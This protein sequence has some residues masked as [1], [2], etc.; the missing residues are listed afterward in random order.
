MHF[1]FYYLGF[2]S[3]SRVPTFYN[4]VS[5]A[6]YFQRTICNY[7]LELFLGHLTIVCDLRELPMLGRAVTFPTSVPCTA[8]IRH[9]TLW[10]WR[11][12]LLSLQHFQILKELRCTTPAETP[13][14]TGAGCPPYAPTSTSVS[15]RVFTFLFQTSL[16]HHFWKLKCIVANDFSSPPTYYSH[17]H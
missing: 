6:Q 11:S 14:K 4:Q 5:L 17:N 12:P 7:S 15:Q 3:H 16:L 9:H 8:T 10:L 13:A 1:I 2:P